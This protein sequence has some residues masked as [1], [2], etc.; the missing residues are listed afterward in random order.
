MFT[1]ECPD[2]GKEV[3][4]A[5]KE[6]P[7]CKAQFNKASTE[8][9]ADRLPRLIEREDEPPAP[10]KHAFTIQPTHLALFF[11][12]LIAAVL[13][14]VYLS[15]PDIFKVDDV[16]LLADSTAPAELGRAFE[17]SIEIAG[18][19]YFYDDEIKPKVRAVVINHGEADKSAVELQVELRTLEAAEDAMPLATFEID[20]E[21]PLAGRASTEIET[22]LTTAATIQAMPSWEQL[23]VDVKPPW[24]AE[25]N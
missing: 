1:W 3:D 17:G 22:D 16:P 18:I 21:G 8:D 5:E 4:V 19:R 9:T 7:N 23:R 20:L 13:G 11:V 10:P 25:E 6:C 12:I 2:C 24:E 14:A 15:R